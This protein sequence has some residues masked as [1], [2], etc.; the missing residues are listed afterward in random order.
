MSRNAF[1]QIERE[2]IRDDD[3]REIGRNERNFDAR[4]IGDAMIIDLAQISTLADA[5]AELDHLDTLGEHRE[6]IQECHLIL[7]NVLGD[8]VGLLYDQ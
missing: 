8:D 3:L 6:L 7:M 1:A 4:R 2:A 5:I